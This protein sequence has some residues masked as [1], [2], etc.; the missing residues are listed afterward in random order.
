MAPADGL[1]PL[2]PTGAEPP[3]AVLEGPHGAVMAIVEA[4]LEGQRVAIPDR[5]GLGVTIDQAFLDAHAA[6]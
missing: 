5:P 6:A 1:Q 4:R 2:D 3:K